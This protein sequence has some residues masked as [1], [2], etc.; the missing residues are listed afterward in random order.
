MTKNTYKK[1]FHLDLDG[2]IADWVAGAAKIVGYELSDPKAYYPT[3]DWIK[4]RDNKRM[5]LDLP[6]M[7]R[8]DEMV[9]LARKF[10]DELGYELVFLTA[11]PHYNDMHWTFWDKMMWAQRYYP[12]I[13]VHFGPYSQDKEKHCQPGDILVDDRPDNCEQWNRVGGISVKVDLDYVSALDAVQA[14]FDKESV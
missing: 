1:T 8:A 13:P 14:L 7:P 10:R 4:I 9:T 12:D 3:E 6:K 2:V 11:I 5:F